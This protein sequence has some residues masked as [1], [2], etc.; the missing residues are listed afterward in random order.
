VISPLA[1]TGFQSSVSETHYSRLRTIEDSWNLPRLA[2]AGCSCTAQ[3][4]E[5][6]R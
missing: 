1:R 4:R 3:M 5:Y 2:S 6:F